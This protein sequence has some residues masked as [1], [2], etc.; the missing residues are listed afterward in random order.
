[1]KTQDK[2]IVFLMKCFVVLLWSNNVLAQIS[3]KINIT[4]IPISQSETTLDGEINE[5]SGTPDIRISPSAKNYGNVLVG[6]S[7]SQQFLVSNT[8]SAKLTITAVE[9]IGANTDQFTVD[10]PG[11]APL[12]PPYSLS[13]FV[14]IGVTVSFRPTSLGNKTATIRVTSNDPD[15]NPLDIVLSGAGVGP[16]IAV[17]PGSKNF[18]NVLKGSSA[19]QTFVISN[20]GTANLSVT[21]TSLVGV[22][23]GQYK[24]DSGGG[25]FTL[26]AAATRN[27]V[28]SFRPTTLG[29]RSATLRIASDD[30]DENPLDVRLTGTGVG[31]DIAVSPTSH[32]YGRVLTGADSIQ[33][34]V[35]S[36]TGAA[37]LNVTATN[38][39]G[40][41]SGQFTIDSGGGAFVLAPAATRHIVVG[42][43]PTTPGNKNATLRIASNDTDENPFD[44]ALSGT[45]VE[46][47]I[48][49]T[50]AFID[51]G[52]VRKDST[53]SQIFILRNNGTADL[54][55]FSTG[56]FGADSLYFAIDIGGGAITLAP[57]ETHD[58]IVRFQAT[59]RGVKNAT[60]QI[61]SNDPDMNPLIVPL[62]ATG[63]A[64]D[65]LVDL[66]TIDFSVIT[67]GDSAGAALWLK[68]MGNVDLDIV[69]LSL[70]GADSSEFGIER[71][72]AFTVPADEST[73]VMVTFKPTAFGF[74]T[75]QLQILSND[76]DKNPAVITL[77][78]RCSE[79]SAPRL[80][81][82]YPAD[83]SRAV[84]QNA[85]IQFKITD[86]GSGVD[87]S[88][89]DVQVAGSLI[90]KNGLDQT[91]GRVAVAAHNPQVSVLYHPQANYSQD[92]VFV[93]IC[94]NDLATPPNQMSA[95]LSFKVDT[96]TIAISE[97]TVFGPQGGELC[98][99]LS[100][101][102][103]TIPFSALSD[104]LHIM[105]GQVVGPPALPEGAQVI[106]PTY[107]FAPD[108][109]QLV[110]SVM[111]TVPYS[112]QQLATYGVSNALDLWVYLYSTVTGRWQ[113]LAP[114]NASDGQLSVPSAEFGYLSTATMTELIMDSL[115]VYGP[116][117]TW[118]T[119]PVEYCVNQVQ[120]N[121][122]H[123]LEY[124]F[125]WGDGTAAPWSADTLATHTWA[126]PGV[127]LIYVQ[128]RCPS[129]TTVR[130]VSNSLS[131]EIKTWTAVAERHEV[132]NIPT[133]FDLQQN[134][135]NPFNP[136]TTIKF[137]IPHRAQIRITIYDILGK[138]VKTLLDEEKSAGY[139]Q[140]A[141]DGEN[142][143]QQ[144]MASGLYIC[145]LNVAAHNRFIKM[146]LLR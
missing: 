98:D 48:T 66:G 9:G 146:L 125:I 15:E 60:L 52:D 104:S 32:R 127:Y 86:D 19:S 53:A 112:A 26:A 126:A 42:F 46:A 14:T 120:T 96:T 133:E 114:A 109:L 91:N 106:G 131:V 1:M 55:V 128:G 40:A 140:V 129:D 144:K 38:L 31:P 62:S 118:T 2:W 87:I 79:S 90:I 17:S 145:H 16:D 8:G 74:K 116:E 28:V 54:T 4:F 75:T 10:G 30:A 37:N 77:K 81:Y 99:G 94:C 82:C 51:F 132:E 72:E 6:A 49:V 12:P 78:G 29:A 141:W 117:T 105:I 69:S 43:R 27:I 93:R 23:P 45:A 80:V 47:D 124:R 84:P 21:S 44:V 95:N 119:T 13:P 5:I 108:G 50:P 59:T 67:L 70:H 41:D 68:N 64:P 122:G 61:A 33:T 58:L 100:G 103:V 76:R 139:Y 22:D 20:S 88:S 65:L 134:Y 73:R 135:P 101:A 56:V 85:A 71:L 35:V 130:T 138:K 24:I 142:Q 97:S 121:Y 57:A 36:N 63:V 107:Y 113:R 102:K 7:S 34:F 39:L 137:Q 25:A 111:I 143:L 3:G 83:S 136:R 89:L 92:S 115:A 18:G 123:P 110:D 11:G